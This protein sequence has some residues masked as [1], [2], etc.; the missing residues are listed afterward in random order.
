[1]ATH[2]F[3]D[4]I[5]RG[6]VFLV[7][8]TPSFAAVSESTGIDME[9]LASDIKYA[10]NVRAREPNKSD[11]LQLSTAWEQWRAKGISDMTAGEKLQY[12]IA[13]SILARYIFNSFQVNYVPATEIRAGMLEVLEERNDELLGYALMTLGIIDYIGDDE[14]MYNHIL[15]HDSEYVHR[16]FISALL[17]MCNSDARY[18]KEIT[19]S[20]FFSPDVQLQAIEAARR[21]NSPIFTD[22]CARLAERIGG[23][24]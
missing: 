2:W 11:Y 10:N 20:E 6:M 13:S 8:V 14:L 1:M 9:R 5:W 16:S 22:R 18:L 12:V 19:E 15:R 3:R 7:C 4:I 23:K 24:P 21:R 17:L